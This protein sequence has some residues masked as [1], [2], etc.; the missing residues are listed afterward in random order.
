MTD[1]SQKQRLM[2]GCHFLMLKLCKDRK[3]N[4]PYRNVRKLQLFPFSILLTATKILYHQ[5]VS[6]FFRSA[7]ILFCVYQTPP[8]FV[9]C[10]AQTLLVQVSWHVHTLLL[11]LQTQNSI[12]VYNDWGTSLWYVQVRNAGFKVSFV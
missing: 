1:E 6:V 11:Q 5:K 7:H 12:K 2:L 4:K 8:V 10:Q 3:S 9:S